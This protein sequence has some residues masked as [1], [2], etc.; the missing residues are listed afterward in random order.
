MLKQCYVLKA[1]IFLKVCVISK[2]SAPFTIFQFHLPYRLLN[3]SKGSPGI[4]FSESWQPAFIRFTCVL[5]HQSDGSAC[6]V[7][8]GESRDGYFTDFQE[9]QE[10]PAKPND[11]STFYALATFKMDTSS[12]GGNFSHCSNVIKSDVMAI[13]PMNIQK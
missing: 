3:L 8:H 7:C 12:N 13:R 6:I 1:S 9:S 10:L 2:Y 5:A 11:V 4:L